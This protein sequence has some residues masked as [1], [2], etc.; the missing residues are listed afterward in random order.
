MS[1]YSDITLPKI[2]LVMPSFNQAAYLRQAIDSVI[3]QGYPNLEFLVLDGGST[4]GTVDIIRRYES[5][6]TYWR[7]HSDAG[8]AAAIREGFEQSSGEIMCWLNSDDL[9]APETLLF[10]GRYFR[11]HPDVDFVVGE[12]CLI[13]DKG[14]V[15]RYLDEP[16]W[17]LNWQLY[18]RNCI[19]QAATFWRR[20][21]YERV[22]GVNPQYRYGMDYDLWFQFL[23]HTEPHY[24]K[25]LFSFQRLHSLT[26]TSTLQTIAAAEL[27]AI[28][29][30][31]VPYAQPESKLLRRFWRLH[32]ILV[33]LLY[34]SYVR[35]YMRKR[36]L[37]RPEVIS[38][39]LL[40]QGEWINSRS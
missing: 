40:E 14:Q 38:A 7:S 35:G 13:D 18:V 15:L 17:N 29:K 33:K 3:H 11:Q 16:Y 2:T 5:Q 37:S 36:A 26:K 32:R 4:D 30:H 1:D 39:P 27:P 21:L 25:K 28:A 24:I 10:V 9:L 20:S 12:E 31:Y 22:Q 19:P 8:Q 34:G 23:R 6:I